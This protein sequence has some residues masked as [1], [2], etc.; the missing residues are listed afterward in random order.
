[1]SDYL[2]ARILC[3]PKAVW[4][5]IRNRPAHSGASRLRSG[6]FRFRI[7]NTGFCHLTQENSRI[8]IRAQTMFS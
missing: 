7:P 5:N 4:V 3:Y 1:M 8:L 2:P 6:Q